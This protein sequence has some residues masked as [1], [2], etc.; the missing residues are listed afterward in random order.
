MQTL[1]SFDLLS[2]PDR[3]LARHLQGCNQVSELALQFKY[4]SDAFYQKSRLDAIRKLL[5]YFHDFGKGTDFFQHKIIEATNKDGAPEFQKAHQA[6][7]DYFSRNKASEIGELL[8]QNDRLSNHAKLGAYFVQAAAALEDQLIAAI[9]LKVIRRHHGYLTNFA[10]SRDKQTPQI[11]LDEKFDIPELELQLQY[12]N[13][14]QYQKILL[15]EG[16]GVDLAKWPCIRDEYKKQL[17]I[18]KL[19]MRLKKEREL[20]Y[21]F[22]QHFLFSLLLAADKGDMMIGQSAD[23]SYY[24][25]ENR[26]LPQPLV[27]VYKKRLFA[28]KTPKPIDILREDAY[29]TIA[30]NAVQHADKS[31]FSLTLPT[32][33]GKTFAAYNAAIQ[34]QNHFSNQY[35]GCKARIVYCLPFTSIIDQNAQILQDMIRAYSVEGTASLD[36][37]WLATHHYLS[38]YNDRY[39]AQQLKNDESE[40]LT[41]GWEQEII[42][43]TFVQ[44]LESIFTNKNRALRK[45]HNMAN[46]IYVL[47]EVQSI[48][49][50][51]FEAVEAA[52]RKM[53]EYFGAKFI[54][55]T[56]TQPFLFKNSDAIVELTDPARIKTQRYFDDMNRIDL[57]QS[58]L[59]DNDYKPREIEE[60][61]QI[62]KDDIE[63]NPEKSF[64]IICNTVA[65]SQL[66]YRKLNQQTDATTAEFIYLS[67]SL[68]PRIRRCLIHKIKRN[69]RLCKRQIIVSTQVVEAGVDIDLDIVYRDFAPIDS[70]NQS[71][72]RCNR[73]GI[74]GKGIVKLFHSGKDKHIYDATLRS[75]TE[76]VLR[77][78]PSIIEERSLYDLNLD[79]AAAVRKSVADQADASKK[80]IEAMQELQLED[81]AASFKLIEQ[82][83]RHY[84]VFIPY[85][86]KAKTAWDKYMACFKLS[87]FERKREIKKIQPLLL[88]FVTRFPKIHYDPPSAQTERFLIYEENWEAYYR[89]LTGF[90]LPK[91]SST[92]I[93]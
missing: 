66:V 54:F 43:T 8:H 60:W 23:K 77:K 49:P 86:N 89:L 25:K 18:L 26:L 91:G 50:K 70:I 39:D 31:F 30:H 74:R 76:K 32:G 79:Y 53:A 7:L 58:L 33:L 67:S 12:F 42:V 37:S 28:D 84:N 34:L 51:Y 35:Y 63:I 27:D 1:S 3:T 40:Y 80:L 9:V 14:D 47:D 71:A 69:I 88:Q 65:Q 85:N 82:D 45:F 90:V 62:F 24:I 57:N 48:P 72:G 22:L 68:L 92:A 4:V 16:I 38:T 36:E 13:T 10:L 78:Y 83:H 81:V 61:I 87:D 29:H 15:A 64:L 56:A 41:A 55:V 46:A 59:K 19:E 20:R 6:Y 5:V 17:K 52:F 75:V 44:L 21:F 93:F 73:N 11:A 2:H